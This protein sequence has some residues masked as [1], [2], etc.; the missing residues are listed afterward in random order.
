MKYQITVDVDVDKLRNE[1]YGDELSV[2]GLIKIEMGWLNNSGVTC[3]KVSKKKSKK[4]ST[5]CKA[6]FC[7][8]PDAVGGYCL[9]HYQLLNQ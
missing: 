4:H 8:E 2:E 7:N 3:I 5:H 9:E 6:E 1:H